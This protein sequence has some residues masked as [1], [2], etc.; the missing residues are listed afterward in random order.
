MFPLQALGKDC[1]CLSPSFWQ[2]LAIPGFPWLVSASAQS[3]PP[4]SCGLHPYVPSCL[5]VQISLLSLIK[6]AV[7]GFMA[8]ST[9]VWLQYD[10]NLVP[11]AETLFHR[12]RGLGVTSSARTQCSLLH[13]VSLSSLEGPQAL[14]F[15]PRENSRT[16]AIFRVKT[17]LKSGQPKVSFSS[18]QWKI[19]LQTNKDLAHLLRKRSVTKNH[20][21]E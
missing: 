10:F 2:P 14:T 21:S 13:S 9:P 17:S 6:T 5:C 7:I 1:P 19:K 16:S 18:K 3:L 12:Y 4:S 8:H 15:V 11:S 20:D